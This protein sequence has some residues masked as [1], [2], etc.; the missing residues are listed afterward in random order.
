MQIIYNIHDK[1]RKN[2]IK[3]LLNQQQHTKMTFLCT[4]HEQ[5]QFSEIY[6]YE[7]RENGFILC[8][9]SVYSCTLVRSLWRIEEIFYFDHRIK[10]NDEIKNNKNAKF[11]WTHGNIWYF[12]DLIQGCW[13]CLFAHK[14]YNF[15]T[16]IFARTDEQNIDLN[17]LFSLQFSLLLTA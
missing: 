10:L 5:K 1:I 17:F 3:H 11:M 16:W 13:Q 4:R 9:K 8:S 15:D 7:D 6:Y 2:A 12:Y 14:I